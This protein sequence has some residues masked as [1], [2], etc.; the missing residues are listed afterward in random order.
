MS[1]L[2]E[3]SGGISDEVYNDY[4]GEIFNNKYIGV[5]RLGKGSCAVVWLVYNWINKKYYALKIHNIDDYEIGKEEI[6]AINKLNSTKCEYLINYIEYF[7]YE[8]DFEEGSHLCIVLELLGCSIYD[9]IKEGKYNNGLPSSFVYKV[10][11]QLLIAIK[12]IDNMGYVHTDI[13][14]ENIMLVGLS[15]ETEKLINKI[16]GIRIVRS[17]KMKIEQLYAEQIKKISKELVVDSDDNSHDESETETESIYQN[18][19]YVPRS[20][21]VNDKQEIKQDEKI[22]DSNEIMDE[23]Y[24]IEPK[25]KVI[26]LGL[27]KKKDELTTSAIQ[28][29]YYR[30][31]EVILGIKYNETCDIWSVGCLIYEMLTGEIL[32][33]PEDD[34]YKCTDRIHLSLIQ[35]LLGKFPEEIIKETKRRALWFKSDGYIKGSEYEIDNINNNFINSITDDEK[36]NKLKF[37]LRQSLSYAYKQRLISGK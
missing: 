25:I 3:E 2:S 16:N 14:P 21:L 6:N 28:T 29:R 26:D 9:L 15:K 18:K 12:H 24:L 17:G 19:F 10:I 31:P 1:G 32:F 30:A 5:K 36:L 20:I 27:S 23:K 34:E 13:K 33:N 11:E 35:N 37:V 8:N 22:I 7:D 4:C